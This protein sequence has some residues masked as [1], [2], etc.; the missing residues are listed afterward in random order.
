VAELQQTLTA[1][2][3]LRAQLPSVEKLVR[4]VLLAHN[5]Q[6]EAAAKAAAAKQAAA[7]A[8]AV[9]KAAAERNRARQLN[10]ACTAFWTSRHYKSAPWRW[11]VFQGSDLEY[12]H[13]WP[14]LIA[15]MREFGF[16]DALENFEGYL[17]DAAVNQLETL[18]DDDDVVPP[19]GGR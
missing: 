2:T 12:A 8:A 10:P 18:Y 4:S 5:Q 14:H 9:E 16:Y 13:E 6:Q 19:G 15:D 11:D 7:A 3:A 17:D 1:I